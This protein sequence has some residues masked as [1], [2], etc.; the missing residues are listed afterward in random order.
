MK[1]HILFLIGS[2]LMVTG[3]ASITE[4]QMV[5]DTSVIGQ[6]MWRYDR[7]PHPGLRSYVSNFRTPD[8]SPEARQHDIRAVGGTGGAIVLGIIVTPFW[9]ADVVLC[10]GFD[11]VLLPYDLVKWEREGEK[12]NQ[13]SE[14]TSVPSPGVASS[15]PQG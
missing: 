9:L 5:S 6:S 12:A 7:G 3:C 11:T 15:A 2:L 1:L 10:A 8:V 4:R 14:P 13:V